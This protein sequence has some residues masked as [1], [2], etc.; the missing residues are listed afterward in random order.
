MKVAEVVLV[1]VAGWCGI[2]A[3]G[4]LVSL[5]RGRRAEALKHSASIAAVAG[6]YVL[7]LLGVSAM[8]KQKVVA[9]GQAQ[10][11]GEMCFAVTGVDEVPGLVAGDDGRVVRV[12]VRVSNRGKAAE[13][14]GA[15]EAYLVDSRGREWGPLAGLSGNRLP[16]RVA[17]GAEM[18]SQ[19]MFRVAKDS[20]GIGLVLTHGRWQWRRLLIGDSDSLEHKRT[21]VGLGR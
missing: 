4:V 9:I 16:G 17:G 1:A 14:D 13:E 6:I 12:A 11:F 19:P 8:Q 21:V 7:V 15:I 3:V 2:G 20:A 10:C 18:V 5:A